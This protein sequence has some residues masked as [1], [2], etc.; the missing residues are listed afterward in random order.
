MHEAAADVVGPDSDTGGAEG[1]APSS[2]SSYLVNPA[3][4]NAVT[5]PTLAPP[6]AFLW[7]ASFPEQTISYPL[8]AGG[9]VYL[10]LGA[11]TSGAG[12][13]VALD[14]TS[15][16]TLWGPVD[17]DGSTVI[18]HAYDAERIF[19]LTGDN[20]MLR[21]FDAATGQLLWSQFLGSPVWSVGPPTAYRG[22]VY[23]APS[24]TVIALDEVTGATL[25]MATVDGAGGSSPAVSDDGVFVTYG[26]AETYAFNRTTGGI[27]W[28]H[29]PDCD[30]GDNPAPAVFG[31]RVYVFGETSGAL[32]VFDAHT[33]AVVGSL[34]SAYYPVFEGTRAFCNLRPSLEA[35]DLPSGVT[36]WTF[37]GDMQLNVTPFAGGG[38]VYVASDSGKIF[39]VDEVSGAEV[40]STQADPTGAAFPVG[41]EGVLIANLYAEQG[42]VAY[43]HVD[44]PDASVAIGDGS[45]PSAVILA[46]G[47][48]PTGLAL[49]DTDV[50]WTNY[51]S[52][53]VRSINKN[54]GQPTTINDA[55]GTY[56]WG[57][58]VD[59]TRVYWSVPN[60]YSGGTN[61]AIMSIPLAGATTAT[62]LASNLDGPRLVVAGSADVYWTGSG[63]GAVE[64][65]PLDGG[66][67]ATIANDPHG[68]AGLAIDAANLYWSTAAGIFKAPLTGGAATNIGPGAAAIAVD[69]TSVYYVTATPNGPGVVGLVP[70]A[71]GAP[72]TLATGRTGSLPAVAVDDQNVYW[73]EGDGTIAEGAVAAVPK[74]GGIVAILA[75]GLSDPSVIAV[76]GSGI[77]FNHPGGGGLVEKVPK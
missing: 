33:G 30:G 22:I 69:A 71:G 52:G 5:D 63:P 55:P 48:D 32:V 49:G 3:H 56:P 66:S 2:A 51:S 10:L 20:G 19:A 6:L 15:G 61:A 38:T 28:H 53:Q 8:I 31:D 25:W 45:I 40:W 76:D 68:G 39:G 27:L 46:S 18:G 4:T 67:V 59:S 7:T 36:A 29:R 11:E 58:A 73:I 12:Q 57:I 24:D 9:R 54:G 23:V 1:P 77:Y 47:E 14:E 42:V 44:V 43:G 21:A 26:C 65:V 70:I 37:D 50:Y 16:A 41:G 75:S 34:S 13:L 17:L 72:T 35:I 62:T 74:S 60:F 64:G